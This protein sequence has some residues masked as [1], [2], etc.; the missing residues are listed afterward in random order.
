MNI[1]TLALAAAALGAVS[2]YGPANASVNLLDTIGFKSADLKT[3]SNSAGYLK[4]SFTDNANETYNVSFWYRSDEGTANTLTVNYD[5]TRLLSVTD[6]TTGAWTEFTTTVVGSGGLNGDNLEFAFR[7]AGG[8]SIG[9]Q[10]DP[11]LT[12]D[13]PPVILTGDPP[14]TAAAAPEP[15]TWALLGL[16][17]AALGLAASFRRR[18]RRMAP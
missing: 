12:V 5:A 3:N 4:L 9:I 10:V 7:S 14:V 11:P 1:R 8:H 2:C 6:F 16:G 18:A 15:S 13:P 17:F